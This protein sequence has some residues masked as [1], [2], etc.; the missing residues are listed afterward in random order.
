MLRDLHGQAGLTWVIIGDFTEILLLS[1]KEGG[2]P[3]Q[4]ASLQAFQDALVDCSLEDVGYEGDKFTWYRGGI[5]ERLD[6]AICNAGWS[7][8][9]L[10]VGLHKQEYGH[11]D[12]RPICLDTEWLASAAAQQPNKVLRFEHVD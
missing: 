11:S 6:M 1:E 10:L 12:H 4:R 3:R 2:A 5:R 9:H 8:M 7:P